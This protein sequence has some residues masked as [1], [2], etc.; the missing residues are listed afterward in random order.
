MMKSFSNLK[1]MD[2][3]NSMLVK[4]PFPKFNPLLTNIPI[5]YKI[6]STVV[7]AV[8]I[9][10]ITC[11]YISGRMVSDNIE[12]AEK[13]RLFSTLDSSALYIEDYSKK[14]RDNATIL[15]N[16]SELRLYCTNGNSIGAS[17]FLVQLA[18]E[19]GMDFAMVADKDKRLLT[20][21]DRPLESG[22]DLSED[23]MI[24][25]GFAGFKNVSMYPS[26]SGI[27]IQAVSPIK[28]STAATGV[29]TIGAIVAQYN[30]DRRF[31]ESIKKIS[32]A[33]I[34]LYSD[35]NVISTLLEEK[36][37][38]SI[39]EEEL[40]ISSV[41]QEK[42]VKTKEKQIEKKTIGGNLYYL[43][44]VPILN[45]R[46]ELIGMLSIAIQQDV[47]ASAKRKVQQYIFAVGL[48]GII[49]AILFAILMSRSIAN[50]I[51][52][53]VLDTKVIANG[54]LNYKSSING[55]D[56]VGQLAGGFNEMADS[57]RKLVDQVLST[58]AATGSST[59]ALDSL[60]KDINGISVDVECISEK[61]K[62]GS[63]N[64]YNYLGQ[65]KDEMEYVSTEAAEISS[66]TLEIT[67][68]ANIARQVVDK[69]SGSL[70]ELSENMDITKAA[71]MNMTDRI[72]DFKLNLQQ[73]RKMV[74][75]V[76]SIAAQTKLLALNA[77]IEAARAGD[78]GR[79]FGVV[80]EEIR[81]L[82]DE[83]ANSIVAV[84]DIIKSLFDE[85]DATKNIAENSACDFERCIGISKRIEQSF[86]E[87]VESFN[88][89]DTGIFDISSKADMQAMNVD[90]VS[91]IIK[92][93]GMIA[94]R[95]QDQSEL[96]HEGAASQSRLLGELI[97]ELDKLKCD[98][99]KTHLVAMNF[100]L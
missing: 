94:Q 70:K 50:P 4:I 64:Q 49:F 89:I 91:N 74:E 54:N 31:V 8:L 72:G 9:P 80:A 99:E 39:T 16:A 53:L 62:H 75:I 71:I 5:M 42:L 81:K 25:S 7:I 35:N 84:Q 78:A 73:I 65:T 88:I 14:A 63:Q 92:D 58:V 28:S 22:A 68:Q 37:P 86:V 55:K 32:G 20:R 15:S 2:F 60:I 19:I 44:Y 76:T 11:T 97:D 48:V 47:T 18:S 26:A 69:E 24:K 43:G 30:I 87:I 95:A 46:S 83:S 13:A 29:Q 51:K 96:M 12:E 59:E 45:N 66:R 3:I 61:V 67:R 77:A 34:T 10:M 90:K 56:E 57:L 38:G 100:K 41:M 52:R 79:G 17:Q 27:V 40:R 6:M 82:S 33:E 98:I 85:M 1:F 23:H 21:T 93:V 36:E